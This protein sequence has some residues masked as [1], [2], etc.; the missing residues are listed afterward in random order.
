MVR[1]AKSKETRFLVTLEYFKPQVVIAVIDVGEGFAPEA[2]LPVGTMRPDFGGGER[3]GGWGLALLEALP[4]KIDYTATEPHRRPVQVEK[5]LHCETEGAADKA[6][7][8]DTDTRGV[9][10]ASKD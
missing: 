1:H 9:G 3:L 6:T 7:E 2:V 5:K 4:D 8:R 10:T